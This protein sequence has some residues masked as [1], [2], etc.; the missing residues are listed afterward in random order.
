MFGLVTEYMNYRKSENLLNQSK[1]LISKS[2][3]FLIVFFYH[4]K[5]AKQNENSKHSR[6]HRIYIPKI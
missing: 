6:F 4:S 3:I 1:L 2:I 5:N